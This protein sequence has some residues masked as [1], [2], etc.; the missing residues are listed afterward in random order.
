MAR[1]GL[2]ARVDAG[3]ACNQPLD[4]L[5]VA[6][7]HGGHHDGGLASDA[8]VLFDQGGERRH[9]AQPRI[10]RRRG[11]N[12]VRGQVC[13]E[14]VAPRSQPAHRVNGRRTP[15]ILLSRRCAERDQA[16]DSVGR[17]RE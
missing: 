8:G 2:G 9:V 17:P 7:V 12:T 10:F 6:E 13:D 3:A 4:H 14:R 11:L 16:I 15:A 5:V 1:L